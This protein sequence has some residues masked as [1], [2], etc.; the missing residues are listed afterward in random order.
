MFIVKFI[1]FRQDSIPTKFT[2]QNISEKRGLIQV[3][4][5][6]AAFYVFRIYSR[7]YKELPLYPILNELNKF[8]AYTPCFFWV[9]FN[10][11]VSI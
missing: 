7:I 10:I 2:E 4:N 9:C 3:V 8:Y 11:V 1:Q 6:F 5:K